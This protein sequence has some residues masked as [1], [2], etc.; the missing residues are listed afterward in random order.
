[1]MGGFDAVQFCL[2]YS[3]PYWER[4]NNVSEGWVGITCPFPNCDDNS[5]HGGINT[6]GGYYNCWKCGG[7][8]LREVIKLLVPDESTQ[9]ILNKYAVFTIDDTPEEP[10]EAVEFV[11]PGEKLLDV[12]HSYLQMRNFDSHYIEKKYGVL[13]TTYHPQYPYRIITPVIFNGVPVSFLGRD[14]TG[15]QIRHKDCSKQLAK[16]HHKTILYNLDNCHKDSVLVVEGAY[17]V[18]RFGDNTCATLG[19]GYTPEQVNMLAQ[20]FKNVSVLFDR[21]ESAYKKAKSLA[22]DL[23]SVGVN[24][25]IIRCAHD[26][27]EFYPPEDIF[28]LKKELDLL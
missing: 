9:K 15:K 13:G 14:Y 26:E 22:L 2:D 10:T 5:N 3:I 23:D 19:I 6:Y 7:H 20:R 18:W 28:E 1:M 27:P 16:I 12:H 24:S 21:S 8:K 25:C 17:D 4:G 11:L